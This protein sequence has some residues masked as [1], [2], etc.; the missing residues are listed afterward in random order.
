MITRPRLVDALCGEVFFDAQGRIE[1]VC[2]DRAVP[3]TTY[4]AEHLISAVQRKD[5]QR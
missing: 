4:C 2:L 5:G 1:G 3:G